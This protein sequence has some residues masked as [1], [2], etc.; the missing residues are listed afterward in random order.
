MDSVDNLYLERYAYPKRLIKSDPND[1]VNIIVVIPCFNEPDLITSLISL[2][3]CDAPGCNVEVIII[4]NEAENCSIDI[5]KRNRQ[6]FDEASQ[7]IYENKSESIDFHLIYLDNLPKKQAGVGLARKIG[8]DEAVRR[9]EFLKKHDNGIIVCF[10][11][12]SQCDKNYFTAIEKHFLQYSLSPACSIYFEHPLDGKE[13][14]TNIYEGIIYYELFLRYYVSALR[15]T[16]FP[17]AFQ[18]IGSSMAVRSSFYQK[19]GGMNK[20][21]AGEDF[22]FL[23]K[24]IPLGNYTELNETRVI[25]SPRISN[26]VPFGTG[27]AISQ[28]V[29]G[30]GNLNNIYDPR[31]FMDLKQFIEKCDELFRINESQLQRLLDSLP[32]SISGFLLEQN[33]TK[34]LIEINNNSSNIKT[35]KSRFFNWFNGFKVLKFVHYARDNH[36][37]QVPVEQAIEWLMN[38]FYKDLEK[39]ADTKEMLLKMR[40]YDRSRSDQIN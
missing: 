39:S 30:T 18:T 38:V 16:G 13:F 2:D 1:E 15:Y 10:D 12:D 36:Y 17:Y 8:M 20:K 33:I 4:I 26:R 7:W 28:W 32:D 23:H 25:P 19:Q 27:K 3:Q 35:F 11:A 29:E 24:L 9:F 37:E 5:S 14:P 34:K 6:T 22:Y 31:S 40:I 21:K